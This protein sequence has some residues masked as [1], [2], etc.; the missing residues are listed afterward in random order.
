MRTAGIQPQEIR[1]CKS[2]CKGQ[3]TIGAAPAALPPG[4][5]M[6]RSLN[7]GTDVA[8]GHV[9]DQEEQDL[10]LWIISFEPINRCGGQR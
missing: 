9:T 3:L 7:T 6:F 4:L 8:N 1:E 5:V 2:A 10:V